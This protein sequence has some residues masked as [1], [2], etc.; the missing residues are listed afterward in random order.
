MSHGGRREQRS[1]RSRQVE[2]VQGVGDQ[3]DGLLEGALGSGR[4]DEEWGGCW[5]SGCSLV[6]DSEGKMAALKSVQSE[7]LFGHG[8]GVESESLGFIMSPYYEYSKE[9]KR[10]Q[11]KRNV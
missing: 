4:D 1:W 9:M 8:W 10:I 7:R 5:C 3:P 11:L 2:E 6:T